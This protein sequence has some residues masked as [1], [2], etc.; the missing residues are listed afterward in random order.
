MLSACARCLALIA[1]LVSA[2]APLRAGGAPDPKSENVAEYPKDTYTINFNDVSIVEFIRFVSKIAR[3][4]FVFEESELNFKVTVVSEE[5]VTPKNVVSILAQVLRA[6]GLMLL[7]QENNI[8][9]TKSASVHQIAT[10]VSPEIPGAVEDNAAIITRVFRIKNAK[11]AQLATIIRPMISANALLEVAEES[12]QLIVTDV[13]ASIDKIAELLVALDS[14]HI[15]LEIESYTVKNVDPQELIVLTKEILA[16]F[17][18]GN[19]FI[20]VPQ[21]TTNEI[22]IV[23]TAYLVERALSVM[24]DLDVKLTRARALQQVAGKANFLVYYGKHRTSAQL[25]ASLRDIADTLQVEGYSNTLLMQAL[26][27]IHEVPSINSL[28]FIGEKGALERIHAI[29]TSLDA[30]T[31]P[32]AKPPILFTY[33]PE[34][35][36]YETILKGLEKLIPS[37]EKTPTFS[38]TELV[39]AIQGMHWV[40]ELHALVVTTSPDTADQLKSLIGNIDVATAKT[41]YIYKLK[42][43]KGDDIIDQLKKLSS[44]LSPTTPALVDVIKAIDHLEWIPSNNSIVITGH[45]TAVDEVKSLISNL[46]VEVPPHITK[47]ATFFIYK[48]VYVSP[49]QIEAEIKSLG[50]E[51]QAAGITNKDLLYT[52]SHVHY[53]PT[54]QSL[55]FSGTEKALEEVKGF[56]A[57]IDVAK[58]VPTIQHVGTVTFLLYKLQYISG[59]RLMATLRSVA[60]SLE[61]PPISAH[62]EAII[63]SIGTMKYIKEAHALLFTGAET[64]LSAVEDLCKKFDIPTAAPPP[65]V[66]PTP[67][68]PPRVAQSYVI[69]E[70]KYITGEELISI[71]CNFKENLICSGVREPELFETI[72]NL[73][74]IPMT[75]ALLVSGNAKA[76]EETQKLLSRFDIPTKVASAPSIE[77][78]ENASFLVYKLQHHKGF[79]I[80]T[81][82]RDIAESIAKSS[83]P[84]PALSD[85]IHSLQW[86]PITNSL[87]ATGPPDVLTRLKD[88]IKNLDTAQ[89]QVF[90]EVLVVETTMTNL[91]SFGLNWGSQFDFKGRAVFSTGNFPTAPVSGDFPSNLQGID[92]SGLGATPN[93]LISFIQGFDLGVIGDVILHKGQTFLSLGSLVNA[94]Q[95]DNDATIIFNQKIIAQD[96]RQSSLFVGTNY[97]YTGALV[98]STVTGG[99][100]TTTNIEYRDVGITLTITPIIGDDGV[101]SLEILQDISALTQP[102]QSLSTTSVT[103]IVTSRAHFETRANVPDSTFLALTGLI[104]DN[105]AHTRVGIPC[106]G[107]LPV[108]GAIFSQN[109]RTDTKNNVI[110]FVR[111]QVIK[112]AQEHKEITEHQ[113]WLYKDQAGFSH[114]KEEFDIGVDMVKTPE[115]E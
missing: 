110:I 91:Q 59:E 63:K 105:K 39:A 72:D 15:P 42:H 6:H 82:L 4:N 27:S 25:A 67:P 68:T 77:T 19:P 45:P 70:P 41:Y 22:Y 111:P 103:G 75:S 48:P 87:I 20:F 2:L 104:Q 10:L 98:N 114:L 80:M 26:H 79:E 47:T 95:S 102:L 84:N 30:T 69:Y 94:L 18:D 24:Q 85:S 31:H 92:A 86:I 76:V 3:Q 33:R 35:V 74:W 46:D 58:A 89:K 112:S 34:Y 12:H 8:L 14:P 115:D 11:P 54:N 44:H 9:I 60:K 108:V 81:A 62:N 96:N 57:T 73:R 1:L 53:V 52:L 21:L 37:L 51:L 64:A 23:S 17:T 50:D 28:V 43:V 71:L 65:T 49:K 16:P 113:E 36:N 56:L 55:I 106:L 38:N 5:P 100:T 107:S 7:E 32:L 78:I 13:A 97:P 109:N 93:K 99:S 40:P 90:I 61:T 101:I 88:L 66:P 83:V 29:L